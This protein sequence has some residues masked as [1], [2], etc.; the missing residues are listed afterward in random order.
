MKTTWLNRSL[1]LL[2]TSLGVTACSETSDLETYDIRAEYEV[3]LN[4]EE[5]TLE[6]SL[7]NKNSGE[8][9]EISSGDRL[10]A[11]ID[12]VD[13]AL[14]KD[15][16][17]WT[18]SVPLDARTV[19]FLLDRTDRDNAELTV[20]V[21]EEADITSPDTFSQ[22][23]DEITITW[24]NPIEGATV[25]VFASSC[26]DFEIGTS[27]SKDGISDTGS[28]TFSKAELEA[29]AGFTPDCAQLQIVR[30]MTKYSYEDD[31]APL[32][33]GSYAFARRYHHWKITLTP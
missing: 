18:S 31:K 6:A 5:G 16:P 14:K 11:I 15:G 29:E 10:S 3:T 1:L 17:V 9:L 32:Y 13:T 30:R 4:S 24:S 22:Q 28:Y 23:D 7:H 2:S 19:S 20:T 21:P 8:I 33:S 26:A 27:A 12:G 25:T